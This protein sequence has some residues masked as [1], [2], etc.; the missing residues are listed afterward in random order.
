MGCLHN[1]SNFPVDGAE[2]HLEVR[3]QYLGQSGV[4]KIAEHTEWLLL[5]GNIM[6]L[7]NGSW[8]IGRGPKLVLTPLGTLFGW[9]SGI[10]MF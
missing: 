6:Q 5:E 2:R 7:P 9:E 4:R 8:I 1:A 3:D 10:K